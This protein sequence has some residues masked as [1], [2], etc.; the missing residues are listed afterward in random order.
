MLRSRLNFTSDDSELKIKGEV[1]IFPPRKDSIYEE[2]SEHVARKL[3]KSE[4]SVRL[5]MIG[6]TAEGDGY[7]YVKAICTNMGLT[8]IDAML[9]FKHLQYIDV[10]HN[11][12]TLVNLQVLTKLPY[13]L[14]LQADDNKLDSAALN[15]MEYLQ[16]IVMNY[17]KITSV[18]D[19][20]QPELST[21]EL[22]HNKIDEVKFERK[23]TKLRCLDLRYNNIKVMSDICDLQCL[24]SLYLAGNKVKSLAGLDKLENLRIL[25]LR[26]NPLK[27]LNGLNKNNRKLQYINLR[28]CMVGT[29][30][31]I[32]KLKV[33][34]ALDTLVLKGTPYFGGTGED[35]KGGD[36][37]EEEEDPDLRIE[38]LAAVPRL[39]KLNKTDFT[40]EERAE[41]KELIA[42]WIEEGEKEDEEEEEAE[43]EEEKEGEQEGEEQENE[44]GQEVDG[45]QDIEEDE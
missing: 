20:Y 30:K 28:S 22:G 45:E 34:P 1:K 44:K 4:V 36:D 33:L 25:H 41:A 42:Q 14:F 8:N 13:V 17:N 39:K 16:V 23:L 11:K 31:Q 27:K 19:V 12:L 21:L 40:D 38:V 15:P 6:K 26:F 37:D 5:S 3:F 24:D 29:L 35:I 18:S 10:S 32:K 2:T 7:T 9:S 43:D